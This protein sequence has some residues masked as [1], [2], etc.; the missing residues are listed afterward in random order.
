MTE[1]SRSDR[2]HI[3]LVPGFFG[4]D[5]L[6]QVEYYAGTT[7]AFQAWQRRR[8]R[9]PAVLH[10]FDNFPTASVAFR[11]NRLH[12]FLAK[13]IAR[14]EIG[15]G[16][17]IA[18]VGHS[19]GGLDIRR[20][21]WDLAEAVAAAHKSRPRVACSRPRIAVDGS[22]YNAVRVRHEAI[23]DAIRRV[24]FLSV[25]HRGTPLARYAGLLRD[26]GRD[27]FL[28]LGVA[29]RANNGAV[30]DLGRGPSQLLGDGLGSELPLA[31]TDAFGES[32]DRFDDDPQRRTAHRENRALLGLWLEHIQNDTGAIDDLRESA[33]SAGNESPAR[34]GPSERD[35]ELGYFKTRHIRTKSY[36]THAPRVASRGP[37]V[38]LQEAALGTARWLREEAVRAPRRL[39]NA[40]EQTLWASRSVV[41]N[42]L[43]AAL[44][45][46][47][48]LLQ[49][50]AQ[51]GHAT[52]AAASALREG[53]EF[54]PKITGEAW[55]TSPQALAI[56]LQMAQSLPS[57]AMSDPALLWDLAAIIVEV[58]SRAPGSDRLYELLYLLCARESFPVATDLPVNVRRA[59][60]AGSVGPH[61]N[62]G[63]VSTFSMM[64]PYDPSDV[65]RH[66][67]E[68]VRCDHADIVG[69]YRRKPAGGATRD[70]A[71]AAYDFF[72]SASGFDLEAFARVWNGVFTFC[73]E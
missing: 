68:L 45:L 31:A 59:I 3:V 33:A 36:L 61:D 65:A 58:A 47:E 50:P 39:M 72:R 6:G 29:V 60:E 8:S 28:R 52:V 53:V 15:P 13:L 73:V 16:D 18:L 11:A 19:T 21:L 5:A 27:G 42:P 2:T 41:T 62:D 17:R 23:L 46:G 7:R 4:F 26:V 51:L 54:V 10:Y 37:V 38:A 57:A 32:D 14:G 64:Y 1:P 43:E 71:F 70:R 49:V 24:V 67:M 34:F 48:G 44:R 25:P 69:H 9:S 63:I 56:A 12:R 55:A 22:R 35:R 20:M 40:A 66:Q 30:T